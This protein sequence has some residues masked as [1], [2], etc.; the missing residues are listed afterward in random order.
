MRIKLK[1]RVQG[2]PYVRFKETVQS[3]K[4]KSKSDAGNPS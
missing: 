3:H 1:G 4:I 2:H